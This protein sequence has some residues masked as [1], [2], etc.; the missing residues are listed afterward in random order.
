MRKLLWAMG[1]LGAFGAG[2]ALGLPALLNT[3]EFRQRVQAE[4]ERS[5]GRKVTFASMRVGLLPPAVALGD[6]VVADLAQ[7]REFSLRIALWPMLARR[8]ARVESIRVSQPR[9]E[10]V[11]DAQGA[12][13]YSSLGGASST[14]DSRPLVISSLVVS[15]G[16]LGVTD[17]LEGRARVQYDHID[18]RLRDWG[19]PTPFGLAISL[20]LPGKG[21]QG[22][23][24]EGTGVSGGGGFDGALKLDDASV[25]SIVKFLNLSGFPPIEAQATGE[26]KIRTRGGN[27]EVDGR[28]TFSATQATMAVSYRVSSADGRVKV[29]SVRAKV[30]ELSA[31][32]AGEIGESIDLRIKMAPASITELVRLASLAGVALKDVDARGQLSA[33]IAVRGPRAAPTYSG[34]VDG[35][36]L[37]LASKAWTEPIRVPAIRLNFTPDEIRAGGFGVEAG[38]TKLGAAFVLRNY[39]GGGGQIAASVSTRDSSL[40]E[41]LRIARTFGA[42]VE[43]VKATGSVTFDLRAKGPV[44]GPL[45][46]SGNGEVR[47]ARLEGPALPNLALESVRTTLSLD[48]RVLNL[49]PLTAEL[50]GGRQSGAI[51]VDLRQAE[52]RYSIR[53]K[54][55]DV[56]AARL[57]AATTGVRA[58]QGPLGAQ[59]DVQFSPG[60][61]DQLARS[62]SGRVSLRLA[63]GKIVGVN[64]FNELAQLGQFVGLRGAGEGVTGLASMACTLDIRD[65]VGSTSDL[66][67]HLADGGA[68]A[69]QGTVNLADQSVNLKSTAV[70]SKE[71]ADRAGGSKVG[72]Y[73]T[74]VL[75]NDKGE[76]VM[77]VLISGAIGKP[78][79]VPDAV[80]IAEMKAGA[81]T[82]GVTDAIRTGKPGSLLDILKGRT[83]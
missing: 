55:A 12:W 7:A 45:A 6:V 25:Q 68:I 37:V 82:R 21:K 30:G 42:G 43:G 11:R 28:T 19:A 27:V 50:Y 41:L 22:V 13:N 23:L 67:L 38:A 36:A 69:A 29:E 62:L 17:H 65:G 60:E 10:L 47:N 56:E 16:Q 63:P 18:V 15:D 20:K 2:L 44:K 31:T 79:I 77:P 75:L 80:R 34:V 39:A 81:I 5:L 32:A 76:L 52:P 49:E 51:Q 66:L 73:L 61:G 26:T 8:E 3:A 57:L 4:L 58:L 53:V 9:V 24:L 54:F 71:L 78:R 74:A 1:G 70:F 72:G 64:L 33:D 59:A 14:G 35:S 40:E 83:K 46:M 48:K